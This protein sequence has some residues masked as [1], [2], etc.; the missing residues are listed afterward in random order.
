MIELGKKDKI[1][2][3]ESL[4]PLNLHGRPSAM[5]PLGQNEKVICGYDQGLGERMIVCD[6]LAEMQKLYDA[7]AQG[8]ALRIYWYAGE[9]TGFVAVL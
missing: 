1:F 2:G 4:K 5:P 7:Y 8:G 9:D 3:A 6:N